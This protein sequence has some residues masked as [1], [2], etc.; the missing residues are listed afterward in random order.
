M[1][2]QTTKRENAIVKDFDLLAKDSASAVSSLVKQTNLL[3]ILIVFLHDNI[4]NNKGDMSEG[5]RTDTRNDLVPLYPQIQNCLQEI[6]A[7][8]DIHDDDKVIWQSN[9]DAYLVAN[10]TVLEEALNRFPKVD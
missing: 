9:L 5:D 1:S 6:T 8:F 10:P 2:K 4:L 7:I 3:K